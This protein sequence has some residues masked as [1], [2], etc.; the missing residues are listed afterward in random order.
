MY[1]NCFAKMQVRSAAAQHTAVGAEMHRLCQQSQV[2]R[3][4]GGVLR[5]SRATAACLGW[6]FDL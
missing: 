6:N 1:K 3:I 2:Q 4:P 5:S